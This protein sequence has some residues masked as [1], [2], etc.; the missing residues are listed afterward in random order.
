MID[1]QANLERTKQELPSTVRLVAV[2]KFHPEKVL[3]EAYDAGQRIFGENKVQ[4][5][6]LKE[7]V[8]P[9]DIKWHFIGHLQ[10]NK[11]KNIVPFIE[12]IESVDSL[13]LLQEINNQARKVGRTIKC[14]LEIHIADEDSKF[15]FSFDSC[16]EM[17]K[18]QSI[19]DL[20]NVSIHGIMGMASNTEDQTQVSNE[21][22]S[23]RLFFNE[24]KETFFKGDDL[25]CELS[26]G[27]S[28]DYLLAIKHGSTLVR[29]GTSI[30]GDR[31]Y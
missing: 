4:E 24:L 19:A 18:N 3:R 31:E 23:L 20:S 6:V 10:T 29:I 13:K 7:G 8:L 11:V 28:H 9:K 27:M 21:F 22:E 25:F 15:G 12:M 26:M 14:L 17:L 5:L 30:F 16:R 2:S 1:I